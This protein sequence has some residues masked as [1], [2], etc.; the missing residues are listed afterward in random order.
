MAK[1]LSSDKRKMTTPSS[2]PSKRFGKKLHMETDAPENIIAMLKMAIKEQADSIGKSISDLQVT[3]NISEDLKELKGKVTH[4]ETRVN[5]VEE[6]IQTLE[7][8]VLKLSR[9]KRRWNLWPHGLAEEDREDVRRKV[10]EICQ[11]MAPD[12]REKFSEVLDSVHSLGQQREFS[13]ASLPRAII[14]QIH[15]EAL[16]RH[17][18]EDGEAIR[19]LDG[20]ETALQGRP[21]SWGPGEAQPAVATGWEST[22]G[23]EDSLLRGS[24]CVCE[25]KGDSLKC[26]HHVSLHITQ[27][28]LFS[29]FIL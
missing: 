22:Q 26:L 18:L 14:M 29:L 4:T 10:I 17:H 13:S 9:Y 20:Q 2:S 23:G 28:F 15:Y 3:V 6:K 24:P 27:G 7:N 11:N 19:L 5:K 21:I 8:K 1:N 12:H 25:Q 16:S